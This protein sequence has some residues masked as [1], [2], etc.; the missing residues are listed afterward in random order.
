MRTTLVLDDRLYKELKL[1][2]ASTG[3]T[4]SETVNALLEASLHAPPPAAPTEPWKMITWGDPKK[5]VAA[6]SAEEL[7]RLDRELELENDL[8]NLGPDAAP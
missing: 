1:R 6:P 5:R 7:K 8:K 4:V 2:A 3:K